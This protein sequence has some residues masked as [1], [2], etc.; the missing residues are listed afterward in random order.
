MYLEK[1][2]SIGIRQIASTMIAV[3]AAATIISVTTVAEES[4][5]SI[6]EKYVNALGG[7]APIRKQK[8]RVSEGKMVIQDFGL[9]GDLVSK[10]K[11]PNKFLSEFEIEGT[12]AR[13]GFDGVKSWRE[14]PNSGISEMSEAETASAARHRAFYRSLELKTIYATLKIDGDSEFEGK[15]T[16]VIRARAANGDVDRLHFDSESG[17][18]VKEQVN[19]ESTGNDR[20]QMTIEYRDYRTV[21]GVKNAFE[22]R[23]FVPN[24]SSPIVLKFSKMSHGEEIDDSVF[25]MP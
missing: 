6:L 8:T 4:T 9:S 24:L 14:D 25:T 7:E 3:A 2:L 20:I 1:I 13:E 16:I 19:H 21:D 15:K 10:Q 23:V 12:T 11:A 17:L 18:L 5:D 22:I